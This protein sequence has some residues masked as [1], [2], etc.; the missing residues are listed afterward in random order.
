MKRAYADLARGQL[1]Y[2]HAGSGDPLLFIHMSA[3]SSAE[4][5]TCGDM[6]AKRFSVFAPDLFGCGF[7]DKPEPYLSIRE[8][9]DTIR[10][11]MDAMGIRDAICAGSLVGANICARLGAAHPERVKGLL[12]VGLCY[13]P[14]PDFYPAL[15]YQPV[16]A[17]TPPSDD[18]GHLM[19]MWEKSSR[20][21]DSAETRDVRALG[22]HLC[23]RFAE[24]MHWA[25][26]EDVDFRECLPDIQAPTVI[27]TYD[28]APIGGPMPGEAAKRIPN[29]RV[30]A[31]K[32]CGPLASIASPKV[33]ADLVRNCF[34]N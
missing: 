8:H 10:E 9:M 16:F 25:L 1:H 21:G 31:L 19:S 11:F 23:G 15:R 14:E 26:C 22:I 29:A 20:Y 17:L 30:I 34:D 33:F 3:G 28:I 32:G 13:H 6:L 5:E 7:S 12:L 2:R 4:F 18:G 24:A 27:A